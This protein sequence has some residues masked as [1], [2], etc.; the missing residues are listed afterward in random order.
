VSDIRGA[1]GSGDDEPARRPM[2]IR[3]RG[4]ETRAA[5]IAAAR[6]VFERDGFLRARIVDIAAAARVATGSFYTYFTDKDEVFAVLME[7]TYAQTFERGV[8]GIDPDHDPAAQIEE[9][10]RTYL[11]AYRR[12]ARLRKLMEQVA[13]MDD[14]FFR[15]LLERALSTARQNAEA[16]RRLQER[17]MAD[18]ELDP[19][20]T[21]LALGAMGSRFAY[22]VFCGQLP[23]QGDFEALV[24][25]V[26]RMWV[27]GIKL[28]PPTAAD[29]P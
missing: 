11:D 19:E 6:E 23:Y 26:T 1:L 21:S 24:A 29:R 4:H 28:A 5:L 3:P 27:N 9:A 25:T 17:G 18:P 10:V 15:I 22:T 2:P 16:I 12:N 8:L 13:N 14:R 7:Q 20:L